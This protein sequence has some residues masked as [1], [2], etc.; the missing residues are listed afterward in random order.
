MILR[1]RL[2]DAPGSF[3]A[4][5]VVESSGFRDKGLGSAVPSDR[6]KCPG[7]ATPLLSAC[8]LLHQTWAVLS[9][10]STSWEPHEAPAS[11]SQ[12]WTVLREDKQAQHPEYSGILHQLVFLIDDLSP[13][14]GS[15]Q[16]E[17]LC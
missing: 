3:E 2:P 16:K 7:T 12:T 8:P 17:R 13:W 10:C 15:F 11:R 5:G 6:C 4:G 14:F 1:I 9:V